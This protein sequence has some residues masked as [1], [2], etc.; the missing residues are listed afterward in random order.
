MKK[1]TILLCAFFLTAGFSI[2]NANASPVWATDAIWQAGDNATPGSSRGLLEN[3]LYEPDDDFL[4]LGL[5]G[6]AIFDFGMEFAST[7]II[8]ETTWG[9]R[10]AHYEEA[11]VWVAG[12]DF[13]F[14]Y[15]RDNLDQNMPDMFSFAGVIDNQQ[16]MSMIDLSVA[17]DSPFRYIAIK[18]N[19]LD[20]RKDGFDI[21]AVGVEPVPEPSTVFLLS[22]GLIGTA[23]LRK[24]FN[25]I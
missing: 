7:A 17:S 4:S 21:N 8:F 22:I 16:E 2:K 3:A 20:S 1:F 14:D 9:S 10:D 11:E 12:A 5:G 15:W 18:D 6:Y 19:T 13:D 25:F 24:K 23:V